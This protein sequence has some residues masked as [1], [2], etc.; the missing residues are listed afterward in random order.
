MLTIS[1]TAP[2]AK[3]QKMSLGDFLGDQSKP[4]P[5]TD[6]SCATMIERSD[7]LLYTADKD[8]CASTAFAYLVALE[9]TNV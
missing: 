2:K 6:S 9:E 3:A 7:T 4:C 8:C 1:S 5:V